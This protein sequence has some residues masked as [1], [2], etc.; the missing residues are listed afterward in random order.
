MKCS[1]KVLRER[2]VYSFGKK[3]GNFIKLYC[4]IM[5]EVVLTGNAAQEA[6]ARIDEMEDKKKG[7]GQAL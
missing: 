1:V 6:R 2:K 3:R 4:P 7:S 5:G